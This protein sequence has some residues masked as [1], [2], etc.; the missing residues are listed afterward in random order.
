MSTPYPADHRPSN[1]PIPVAVARGRC[2]VLVCALVL[3]LGGFAALV[4][5]ELSGASECA[6]TSQ[7]Q[8]QFAWSQARI[9]A[10]L[11]CWGEPG[12][13]AVARG[14][15][16][17]YVFV[18][19]YVLLLVTLVLRLGGAVAAAAGAGRRRAAWWASAAALAA[20]FLD[21]VENLAIRAVLN[22]ATADP[23]GLA[24]GL[25]ASVKFALAFGCVFF[26]GA[27]AWKAWRTSVK[28]RGDR[29]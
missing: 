14:L 16:A 12:R 18:A 28:S 8:L 20:G 21:V 24:I 23:L 19:G 5:F 26:V 17:D 27:A 1:A 29:D 11:S 13:Q 3:T 15:V 10:Q 2:A 22:G 25:L 6:R 4:C 9:E 7:L